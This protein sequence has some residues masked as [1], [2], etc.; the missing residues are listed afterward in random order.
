MNTN[1]RHIKGFENKYLI[2]STGEVK[3]LL[4]GKEKVLKKNI[5]GSG[6][7]YVSLYKNKKGIKYN[8]H[9]LVAKHFL[10]IVE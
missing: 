10:E 9:R 1:W 7:Y 8:V 4:F 6:Y 3:S 2:S 5:N